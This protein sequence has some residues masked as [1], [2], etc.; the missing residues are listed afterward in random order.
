MDLSKI[1]P[2]RPDWVHKGNYGSVMVIAGSKLYTG[3]ATL[4]AVSALRAGADLVT[5]AAPIRASDVA[6]HTLCDLMTFPLRGDYLQMKHVADILDTAHVRKVNSVVLGCGLGR[7][8]ST[9]NAIYKLIT[10]LTALMVLD[11]DALF[12]IAQRPEVCFGKQVILTPHAGELA[13]LLGSP[14]AKASEGQAG[15]I[16]ENFEAR[17]VAAKQAAD[18][19]HCLVLVKGHVDIVTDG[20][21]TMTNNSGS[22]YMTKGGFGDTL[23][24]VLGALLARGVGIFEAACAAA[25]INGKAGEMAAQAN[26]EG[27]VASDIFEYI[28]RVIQQV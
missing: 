4:A 24:G 9:L 1:Y 14:F 7:H 22:V 16:L 21:S 17:L 13:I 15:A 11:A 27:I 26:G 2:L 19:Y 6:A 8:Q 25:Y 10:K 28:P 5:V 18:K 12:A 3:S 23:A 20:V